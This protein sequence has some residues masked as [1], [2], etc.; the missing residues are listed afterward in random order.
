MKKTSYK[1]FMILLERLVRSGLPLVDPHPR[2][3]WEKKKTAIVKKKEMDLSRFKIL[4]DFGGRAYGFIRC[5]EPEKIDLA[6]FKKTR[7]KHLITDEELDR[8][9]PGAKEL[10]TYGIRDFF[11]FE[12]ARKI[13]KPAKGIQT[14]IEEVVFKRTKFDPRLTAKELKEASDKELI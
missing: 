12:R 6:K 7:A 14:S 8:W 4:C 13:K 5:K 10:W 9:W 11:A 2:L 3:I 1:L